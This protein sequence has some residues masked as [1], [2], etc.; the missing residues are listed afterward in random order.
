MSALFRIFKLATQDLIVEKRDR[1]W[2]IRINRPAAANAL[3][4]QTLLELN[5]VLDSLAAEPPGRALVI[6]GE[7]KA[8]CAGGDI[9]EMQ[10]MTEGDA[11]TFARLAQN[12]MK[13][14]VGL[15]KPV[16][17]AV[18]GP[19]FGAGFDLVTSCDLA[20]ASQNATFGS[21]TLSLGIIT[22]FGGD[23][24]L[25]RIVGPA[26]AKHL[27]FTSETL[28]A[29]TALQLGLINKVVSPQ[30]LI[31]EAQSLAEVVLE[32]A[33]VALGF[34]KRLANLSIEKGDADLDEL[35]V[36]LYSKCFRTAD[37]SE[38]MKAFLEKRKPTFTGN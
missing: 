8:F 26:R 30:S 2:T 36:D 27:I 11:R 18:N 6:T 38:G 14:M 16:I 7:G 33:P 37:R 24:I 32:K 3:R 28:D 22:P 4:R 31:A 34:A 19:A 12:T 17:A 35:E 1:T 10:A 15:E 9:K 25:P 21:P 13:K 5:S 23:R 29:P 20:V